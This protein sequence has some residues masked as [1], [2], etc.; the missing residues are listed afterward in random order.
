MGTKSVVERPSDMD[1]DASDGPG[2]N[3]LLDEALRCAARGW[4]VLPLH[5]APGG[6]CSC[7]KADC[8]SPG[9]H[10]RTRHGF[11]DAS[12]DVAVVRRWWAM[13]PA[14]NVGLRTGAAS[15]LLVLDVDAG[16][17]KDGPRELAD[18]EARHGPLPETPQAL[19]GGRGVHYFFRHPGGRVMSTPHALGPGLDLR[20]D[21]AY[22][23]AP[24]SVHA[25]GRPYDWEVEH[26]P[27]ALPLADV[28]AW[29][30]NGAGRERPPA[31]DR[32][33]A[34]PP[35]EADAEPPSAKLTTLLTND[36]QFAQTWKRERRDLPSQS[37]Y[38]LA[39]ADVAV[40]AGWS[41]AEIAAL[42]IAHRRA[43][44]QDVQKALRQ[45]YIS[46]TVAKARASLREG[47]EAAAAQEALAEAVRE[48]AGEVNEGRR[49][50]L[51]RTVSKVLDVEVSTWEQ[52]GRDPT[53]GTFTLV[54]AGGRRVLVGRGD[55]VLSLSR[56]RKAV[57]VETG[58]SI[59]IMKAAAWNDLINILGRVRAVVE[60]PDAERATQ[61]R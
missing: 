27:D 47:A 14:A 33:A 26:H 60:N 13:W 43:G 25:S 57:Y 16:P 7:G 40:R 44:G 3:A 37:E 20:A 55:D 59:P 8:L 46:A 36:P 39:L 15:G 54:R 50:E 21:D 4:P 42:I 24:P 53:T 10:P 45:D 31:A 1:I 9:K 41:D 38:D 52:H 23:V 29:V 22:V 17:G 51:L 18:L 61:R 6:R 32:K 30:L 2:V 48:P 5:G 28:P 34:A 12:T 49:A 56:F 11:K 58:H 35:A 19:T